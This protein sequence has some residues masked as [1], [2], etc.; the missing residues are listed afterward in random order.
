MHNRRNN[1]LA[2]YEGKLEEIRNWRECLLMSHPVLFPISLF[3]SV[4]YH[5]TSIGNISVSN[6]LQRPA[7][8]ETADI[9]RLPKLS[10]EQHQKDPPSQLPIVQIVSPPWCHSYLSPFECL[11]P[12]LLLCTHDHAKPPLQLISWIPEIYCSFCDSHLRHRPP[13]LLHQPWNVTNSQL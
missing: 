4:F 3:V 7:S 6:K 8:E 5:S 10:R 13:P 9:P 11:P 12:S 2:D 1:S